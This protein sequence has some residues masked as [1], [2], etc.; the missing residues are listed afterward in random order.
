MTPRQ[1]DE[2]SRIPM[3]QMMEIGAALRRVGKDYAETLLDE[4]EERLS[5][6]C[7]GR[8]VEDDDIT[9]AW[10]STLRRDLRS[11]EE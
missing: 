3:G 8:E 9:A 7:E 2:L 1:R 10:E 4:Y 6:I 5:I 11:R